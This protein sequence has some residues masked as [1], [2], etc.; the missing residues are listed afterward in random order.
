MRASTESNCRSPRRRLTNDT[1]PGSPYRSPSKCEEIGL[2]Q[3][4]RGP[5]L[6]EG[7]PSPDRDGRRVHGAVGPGEVPGVNPVGRERDVVADLRGWPSGTPARAR[8]GR[9]RAPPAPG[10][11]GADPEAWRRRRR[12]P[13]PPASGCGWRRRRR[14]RPRSV[15]RRPPRS[16]ARPRAPVKQGHVP[17]AAVAEVEVLPH[18]HQPGPE[19]VDQ[20]L[21]DEVLGRLV[22]PS[23]VEG[24]SPA[25][26]RR[27]KSARSSSFCSRSVSC[28]GADSGRT[29]LAGW[30]SK[31][32]TTVESPALG[33]TLRQVA[34]Q[35]PMPQ[36][37][38]V[39]GADGDGCSGHRA[40]D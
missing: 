11:R 19:G 18:H 9:R 28:R 34:Q 33:G 37:H 38:A 10:P 24:R 40:R 31:V 20:H 5:G 36:V 25:C 26:D 27:R 21:L 2:H 29:T 8:H 30:R 4:R 13:G 3:D 35:G 16:R 32:T 39:V 23:P 14:C 22:G 7:G 12:P 15:P 6:V 1:R 17:L